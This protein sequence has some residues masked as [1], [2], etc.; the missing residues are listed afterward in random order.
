MFKT[1]FSFD[2]SIRR[3]EYGLSMINFFIAQELIGAMV[4]LEVVK[5]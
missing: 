3:T 2:G 4:D 1:P 5:T